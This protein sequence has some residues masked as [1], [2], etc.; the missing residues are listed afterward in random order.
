MKRARKMTAGH[1]ALRAIPAGK[2]QDIR[3]KHGIAV[4]HVDRVLAGLSPRMPLVLALEGDADIPT[5]AWVN[6]A[7]YG[8]SDVDLQP[9]N[10]AKEPLGVNP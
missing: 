3:R 4:A 6:P 2:L 8:Q 5:S 1:V 7:N 10:E 9:K